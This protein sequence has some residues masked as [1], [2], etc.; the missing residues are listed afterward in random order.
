[1]KNQDN[2]AYTA[3][4]NN[5]LFVYGTLQYGQS[6]NYILNGLKYEKAVLL[7]HRKVSPPSLNF[8]F[9]VQQNSSE[10]EGEIYYG[11]D[12][13]LI[14]QIDVIEGAGSLYYRVLVKVK[15]NNGTELKAF[16]YYPSENLIKHYR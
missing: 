12:K 11:L 2:K 4:Y 5:N 10:V 16:T 14:K 13:N 15:L 1:M 6:R 7:N 8:P 9:I 3:G